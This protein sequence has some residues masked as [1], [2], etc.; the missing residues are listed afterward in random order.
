MCVYHKI[1]IKLVDLK[2]KCLFFAWFC[3]LQNYTWARKS[4]E[5]EKRIFEEIVNVQIETERDI[6]KC[7]W[8]ML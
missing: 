3:F 2:K 4:H 1:E 5:E 7:K 6:L 8:D